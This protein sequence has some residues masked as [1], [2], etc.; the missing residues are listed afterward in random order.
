MEIDYQYKFSRDIFKLMT[1][2]DQPVHKKKVNYVDWNKNGDT[3]VTC[4]SDLTMKIFNFEN[5][6]NLKKICELKGHNDSVYC[7]KFIPTNEKI[8]VSSS[9]DKTLKCW[10]ITTCKNLCTE[11]L[12][13]YIRTIKIID[14]KN[15]LTLNKD[16]ESINI[17]SLCSENSI[18]NDVKNINY[19]LSLEKSVTLEDKSKI[20]DFEISLNFLII[21]NYS[22]LNINVYNTNKYEILYTHS[23]NN[24]SSLSYNTCLAFC[25]ETLKL[26]VGGNNSVIRCYSVYDDSLIPEKIISRTDYSVKKIQLSKNNRYLFICYEEVMIDVF[27]L[28]CNESVYNETR[29]YPYM[30]ISINPNTDFLCFIINGEDS[31]EQSTRNNSILMDGYIKLFLY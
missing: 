13:Q 19:R 2:T 31:N 3:L 20:S 15:I 28:F 30:F 17:Y 24:V 10:D 18:Q 23:I 12:K 22:N 14:E 26:Y 16:E 27:D 9:S 4:S 1:K 7:A 29:K 21:S 11:K 6:C 5:N 25:E 8:I